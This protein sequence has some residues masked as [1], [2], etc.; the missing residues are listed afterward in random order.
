MNDRTEKPVGGETAELRILV[1][2][3]DG[4]DSG[5]TETTDNRQPGGALQRPDAEQ[6]ARMEAFWAGRNSA[7]RRSARAAA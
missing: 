4:A 7:M 3:N 1:V 5:G 6:K 2:S